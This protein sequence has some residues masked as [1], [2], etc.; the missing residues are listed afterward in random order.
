MRS[1]ARIGNHPIHPMIVPIA[2]GSFFLS[3]LGD[4]LYV[5]RRPADDGFW[6]QFSYVCMAVG[7]AFAL[8]AAVFGTIDYLGVKMSSRAFRIATWHALLNLC[9]MGLYTGSF[10]L[11]RTEAASGN[12]R[13]WA[14]ALCLST[15]A[16]LMLGAAGWL[17]GAL[18]HE[19]RVGV[20]E[21]GEPLEDTVAG[22]AERRRSIAQA[23]GS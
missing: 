19:H 6:F 16:F 23:Q 15:L 21:V 10:F 20:L 12:S 2:V 3:F 8:A 9:V 7:I 1:Y 11:R 13:L 5:C 22:T 17:G 14:A 18:T 4:L